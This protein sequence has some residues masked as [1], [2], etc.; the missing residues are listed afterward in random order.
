MLLPGDPAPDF[1]VASSVNQK[2]HFETVAGRYIVLSFFAST[3]HPFSAGLLAE[4]DRRRERFDVTNVM[5]LGVSVDQRDRALLSQKWP[6]IVYFWDDGLAVS[7]QY[8]A[9]IENAAA[10]RIPPASN[11]AENGGERAQGNTNY[12]PRT[13]VLDQ[14]LRVVAVIPFKDTPAAHLDTVFKL[15]DALPPLRAL[16]N[17]APVLVIPYIFEPEFCSTLIEYYKTHGGED[18]GFMRDVGGKTVGVMDYSHKRR[19]DCD[20]RDAELVKGAHQRLIR[21]LVPAIRQAFQFHV[22]RI[23]RNIV[24][25]YDAADGGHFRAHRDNTT[26]GTAHR[27]F[28]VTLNLNAHE[29]DGGELWFPEF[30]ARAYKPP[31]G[32]VVVFS[33]SLMHEAT[34]VI[35]G[36]RYAYL[37]FLYDE[38][39][40]K[41]REHNRQFLSEAAPIVGSDNARERA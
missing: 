25:C 33:C 41:I 9:V 28:A 38:A 11:A 21:R 17:P 40:A 3:A 23:E 10:E 1:T 37:P 34:P 12:Q 29:Y 6:G 14:A 15:I 36:R 35:K 31:T 16:N 5:F 4:V 24:A 13:I 2:F 18:S 39:A 26:L 30:G 27:R 22:T 7:K 32:G 19:A 8:G 20:I